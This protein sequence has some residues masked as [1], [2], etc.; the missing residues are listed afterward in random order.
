MGDH[1]KEVLGEV[2]GGLY[3]M[4][5]GVLLKF[6]TATINKYKNSL[7]ISNMCGK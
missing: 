7:L 3:K 5:T 2:G 4:Y 6:K 1:N